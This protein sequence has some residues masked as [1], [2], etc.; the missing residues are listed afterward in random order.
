MLHVADVEASLRFYSLL[1]LAT[2]AVMRDHAGQPFW[3]SAN[4]GNFSIMFAR[5]SGPI[6][7]T[8]QAALLYLYSNDV[9]ALRAHLLTQ[10]LHDGG[11]FCGQPGPN[12]GLDVVFDVTHPHYMPAGE[13]R[14]SD[15]DGYCLLIGQ[16]NDSRAQ[17]HP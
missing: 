6:D 14:V 16:L 2:T 17:P 13:I 11:S 3:G 4:T 12:Q 5:A 15:P 9:A 10:G 8:Q 1:G 7:H